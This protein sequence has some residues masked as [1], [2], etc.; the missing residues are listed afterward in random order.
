LESLLYIKY[1]ILGV[2]FIFFFFFFFFFF[3]FCF[4]FFLFD[5]ETLL[6][7]SFLSRILC[8]AELI[9]MYC[10]NFVLLW[11]ILVFPFMVFES[12]V[13]YSHLGWHL[14]SLRVC[15]T[16]VQDLL[17]FRVLVE[18]SGV[19]LIGLSLYAT[20]PF[21]VKVLNILYLFCAFS[22]LIIM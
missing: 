20:W 1:L 2:P 22:V 5:V 18:K 16:F 7:W 17:A 13:E 4:C 14:C 12:F 6:C 3:W 19:I 8:W 15:M 11:N 9:D 21:S 10:L